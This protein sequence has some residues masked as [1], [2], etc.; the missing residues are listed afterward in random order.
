MLFM[1]SRLS[2][3]TCQ[4]TSVHA[5]VSVFKCKSVLKCAF[6]DLSL[7]YKLRKNATLQTFCCILFASVKPGFALEV[8]YSFSKWRKHVA[9]AIETRI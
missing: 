4:F 6:P 8:A 9:L 5:R 2:F 3:R 1:L 7:E